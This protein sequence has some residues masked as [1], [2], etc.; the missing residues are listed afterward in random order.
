LYGN[1]ALQLACIY[2]SKIIGDRKKKN[3]KNNTV[4]FLIKHGCKTDS[5]NSHTGFTALHWAARYGEIKIV[6]MLIKH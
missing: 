3:K 1:N 5:I 6:E 2:P 4:E